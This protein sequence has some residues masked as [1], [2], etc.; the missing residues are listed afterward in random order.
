MPEVRRRRLRAWYGLHLREGRRQRTLLRFSFRKNYFAA[1]DRTRADEETVDRRQDG[2]APTLYLEKRT[3]V[4]GV[5]GT[6][7]RRQGGVRV[8]TARGGQIDRAAEARNASP[9]DGVLGASSRR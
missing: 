3:A 4:R 1:A 5:L 7:V 8:R 9:Q 6:R 2:P